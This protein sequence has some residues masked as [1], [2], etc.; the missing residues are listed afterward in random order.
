MKFI[1][2]NLWQLLGPL[3]L[4]LLC[5]EYLGFLGI[6][7]KR[8]IV[9][10]HGHEGKEY[11]CCSCSY[12]QT[13][14]IITITINPVMCFTHLLCFKSTSSCNKQTLIGYTTLRLKTSFLTGRQECS[15]WVSLTGLAVENLSNNLSPSLYCSSVT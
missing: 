3:S 7:V 15:F 6:Q 12:L 5:E 11:A 8:K 9:M 1:I 13:K 10:D 4:E 14:D 2:H